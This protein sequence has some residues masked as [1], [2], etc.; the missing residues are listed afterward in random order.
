[1]FWSDGLVAEQIKY[2]SSAELVSLLYA[3]MALIR[4]TFAILGHGFTL[5]TCLYKSEGDKMEPS[6][7]CG[8]S[9]T[10]TCSKISIA[11]IVE[12]LRPLYEILPLPNLFGFRANK[13]NNDAIFVMKNLTDK[14]QSELFCCFLDLKA[15]YD[16]IDWDTLFKLL[17]I[18]YGARPLVQ[19]LKCVYRGTTLH[20]PLK[21]ALAA[22]R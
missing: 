2:N 13:S 7:Y 15:M 8:L 6:N 1:M 11:I 22:G 4:S 19:L 3:L 5:I 17:E 16:W 21:Q 9:I 10:A 12:H 18:Q 20:Q 14:H